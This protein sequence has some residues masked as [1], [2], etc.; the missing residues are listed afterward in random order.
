MVLHIDAAA[1]EHGHCFIG[2]K[3]AL[4]LVEIVQGTLDFAGG[5]ADK[6]RSCAGGSKCDNLPAGINQRG[7]KA[8][9]S[10]PPSG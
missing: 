9:L 7:T 1:L 6:C 3:L 4:V 10:E 5:N 8:T 2:R